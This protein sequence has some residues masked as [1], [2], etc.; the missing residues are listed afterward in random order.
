M[1]GGNLTVGSIEYIGNTGTGA[2]SQTGGTNSITYYLYLGNV[3]SSSGT[4]TLS[5]TGQLSARTEYIGYSGTGTLTQTGATNSISSD[6]GDNFLYLGY[7][8]DSS[9]TY[10]LNDTGQLSAGQEYI[11]YSGRGTF[12]Q[13]GGNN[14]ISSTY[15]NNELFLGYSTE[16]SG[17]YN[18]SSTGQLSARSENVGYSGTGAFTQTGGTNSISSY[19]YVAFNSGS[20]GSYN[21]ED[22]GHL[23]AYGEVIGSS[24]SG[25]FTQIGG[26]NTINYDLSLGSN[27][28]SSGTYTL[29]GTSQLS[30]SNAYIGKSGMGTFT[31]SGG[32]NTILNVYLG[33]NSGASGIYKLSD[34]GQLS[35]CNMYIGYSGTGIFEQTG[36]M[37]SVYYNNIYKLYLGYNPGSSGTYKLS[38]TGLLSTD[39]EYIGYS[40]T[41]TF[42]QTGGTNTATYVK[43]GTTGTYTLS[44]GTLN[45]YGGFENHGNCDLSNSSATINAYSAIVDLSHAIISDAQNTSFN[46]DSHSILIVPTGFDPNDYF[47]SYINSGILHQAGSPLDI[48]SAYSINGIGSI[49][50]HV[51]CE[52][53]LAAPSGY[54]INLNNG[55]YISGSGSVN[56]GGSGTLYVKNTISGMDGGLLN[57]NFQYI[58]STGIGKFT[59]TGGTNNVTYLEIGATGSYT[60]SGGTLNIN[61]S[62]KNKGIWDLSNSSAVINASSSIVDLSNACLPMRVLLPLISTPIRY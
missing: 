28:G 35:S 25:T 27:I 2:F 24:G 29:S 31:Q 44:G 5:D 49:D 8:T 32:M 16:S 45:I 52:G 41:G 20:N 21:L 11:G 13:T 37:N 60:L 18:L 53:T 17:T 47:K 9:G 39:Y 62:F 33:Y 58:G 54:S 7:N 14:S 19:L 10:N 42:T 61:G 26:T 57:A 43:I 56:L 50:D 48:S 4:Y 55:L 40:G 59:Q 30:A 15:G 3:S 34:N 6:Y 22:S 46:V 36:G 38:G 1:K 23:S 12:I 51:T